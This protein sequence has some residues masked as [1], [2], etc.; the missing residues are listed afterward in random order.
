MEKFYEEL[1]ENLFDGVYYVDREK[2]ITFWNKSAEKISGYTKG[3]VMGSSCG[4][5]LLKHIDNKGTELCVKGC[6]VG[7]TL[8]DGMIREADVYLHHKNGHRVPV[9]IRVSPIRD[10]KDDIVG[11]VEL[12]VDNSHRKAILRAMKVL[13]EE[14]F[15]D[16]LTGV[17]NRRFGEMNLTNRISELKT[18]SI[19]FGLLFLDIDD[20]K[21][22]NDTYGHSVGDKVLKMVGETIL[23]TLRAMDIICRWG[24][25]EFI[26][27][28]PNVDISTL[29][30]V[31][32]RIRVL[33]AESWISA[34]K[35]KLRVT[36]SIGGTMA[37][38]DDDVESLVHRAD[39][40]M[41][42]S[43]DSGR[44]NVMVR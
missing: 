25:E 41:Y 33:V 34:E 12:F 3:E 31:A 8:N 6:P 22:F 30:R 10:E 32:E 7:R 20:F 35:E 39:K 1:L 14:V 13:K 36:V 18:H 38:D 37:T 27:I 40:L 23:N 9:S 42:Q 28:L 11:A 16:A 5:D 17:G 43:K 2:K 4:D 26:V 24:G 21:K 19:P 44:D 29:K 15:V